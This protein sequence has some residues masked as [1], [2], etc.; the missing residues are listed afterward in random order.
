MYTR[1]KVFS[2][3]EGNVDYDYNIYQQLYSE[4][5]EDGVNY[6][7]EKMFTSDNDLEKYGDK[8]DTSDITKRDYFPKTAGFGFGRI[9]GAKAGSRAM[10]RAIERGESDEEVEKKGKR[11]ALIRAGIGTGLAAV[12]GIAAIRGVKK[13]KGGIVDLVKEAEEK[14]LDSPI[15]I[16]KRL[17][18]FHL[19][20][21]YKVLGAVPLAVGGTAAIVGSRRDT[22][23]KANELL[24]RRENLI[25]EAKSKK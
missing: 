19:P 17:E 9:G 11:A 12:P 4:A 8:I 25:N 13:M 14:M 24:A 18:D 23:D 10:K 5:F 7:I 3:G 20:T 2:L 1:R 15:G 21:K 22:K 6:A 16:G